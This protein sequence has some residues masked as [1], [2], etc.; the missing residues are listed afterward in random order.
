MAK[1]FSLLAPALI[2][3]GCDGT[4]PEGILDPNADDGCRCQGE[5]YVVENDSEICECTDA[6][7]NNGET[8]EC[9]EEGLSCTTPESET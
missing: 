3:V 1:S 9:N 8:C 7:S 5:E 2:L 4:C 6:P